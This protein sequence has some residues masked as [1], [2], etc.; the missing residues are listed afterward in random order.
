MLHTTIQGQLIVHHCI[1]ES[2]PTELEESIR[3]EKQELDKNKK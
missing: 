1:T 2:K 3:I